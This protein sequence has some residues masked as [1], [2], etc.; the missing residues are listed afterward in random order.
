LKVRHRTLPYSSA[1]LILAMLALLL[2]CAGEAQDYSVQDRLDRIERD[3]NML[4]RQVYRGA[5]PSAAATDPRAAAGAEIRMEQI[6]SQMRSLTGRVEE[7]ANSVEQ[8]RQRLEQ[9][10]SDID[11]R[12]GEMGGTGAARP[13]AA[14]AAAAGATVAGRRSADAMR[15]AGP[16]PAPGTVVPPPAD[17]GG[18]GNSLTPI[19]GTL[20]PP[21]TPGPRPPTGAP[22]PADPA[23]A[24]SGL[25][26]GSPAQQF[27]YAFGLVKQ[28]DYA[29]AETALRAFVKAH[30]SDPMAGSA[31]YWLGQTYFARNQY[32]DAA[33]AFA[34]GYKRYP[35][36]PKAAE[37]LLDLGR[38]LAR[39]DQKKNACVALTQLD[40]EFP[41]AGAAI[42]ERAAAEKKRLGC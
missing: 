42:R 8:L 16:A 17:S 14:G 25:P 1:P 37:T 29:G 34:D 39:A 41:H 35:K 21:G 7:L 40:H 27:N 3:V 6:E 10:N 28:R 5:P 4:Q 9:V 20:T 2:P 19:F 11:V 18:G 13:G 36:G 26:G 15:V 12:M 38:S 30:P 31:Q 23:S 22:P 33:A 24:G 32:M